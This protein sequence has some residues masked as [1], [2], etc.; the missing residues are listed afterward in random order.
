VAAFLLIVAGALVT[1]NDAGLSIP[2]WPTSF[3]SLYRM[4][5]MVG[6]VPF[7]HGHRLL[8]EFTGLLTLILVLWT[9]RSDR[10]SWMRKLALAALLTV[11]VQAMLGGLTVLTSLPPALSTAHAALGQIFFC[12]AVVIALFTGRDWLS[13]EPHPA[14]ERRRPSLPAL[15]WLAVAAIFVQLLLGSLFRHHAMRLLP[16]LVVAVIVTGLV[17]WTVMRALAQPSAVSQL[18]RPGGMLLG[19]LLVQLALGFTAYLTRVVWDSFSGL[20][21]A[22]IVASTV[23]HV[24]VG[25]LLLATALVLVIQATR[26]L[27][28]VEPERRA[29]AQKAATA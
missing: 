27:A 1:S 5:P 28:V 24:S 7:E 23:A 20:P 29:T 2:D 25:A 13:A 22:A 4:P 3:G 15:A 6:G 19:L 10:R 12:L 26:Q 9:W 21:A 16:H 17:F 14:I 8:G 11:I 18:R